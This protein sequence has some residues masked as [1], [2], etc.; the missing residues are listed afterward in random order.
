MII[1][2]FISREVRYGGQEEFSVVFVIRR[3]F[4][5]IVGAEESVLPDF[6]LLVSHGV[7]DLP[8]GAAQTCA[9]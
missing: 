8:L 7:L 6:S 5:F 4:E 3:E 9:W 1:V 2:D